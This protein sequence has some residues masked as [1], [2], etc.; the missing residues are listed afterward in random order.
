MKTKV[1]LFSLL[2]GVICIACEDSLSKVGM[3][4]QP[5]EDKI[6]VYDTTMHVTTSTVKLDSIYA[7][8]T[9]G[10]LGEIYDPL[11]GSIKSGYICQYYPA[12]GYD[13]IVGNEIDSVKLNVFYLSMIGDSLTPMEATVFP[14]VKPLDKHYYTNMK[15]SDYCDLNSP[16]VRYPYTAKNNLV[17][18]SLLSAGHYR[19]LTIALP[20][21][22]GQDL[23]E[24]WKKEKPN[25]Y[26]SV[27]EF[28]KF[29][30]G[31]YLTTTFGT[32]SMIPVGLTELY[33]Y[34]TREYT[35]KSSKGEDSLYIAAGA[36]MYTVTKEVIQLNS[37]DSKYEEQLLAPN[38]EKTYVKTPTG[39][40]TKIV[41]PIKEIAD[42]IGQKKFS[43]VKLS[44]KAYENESVDEIFVLPG[45]SS[46]SSP[47]PKMLL[48]EPDS[49][50]K[51]FEEQR[52]A[53][54]K[55]T[56]S[57]TLS[58]YAY[59]FDNISNVVQNAIDKNPEQD[60]ELLL[61]PVQTEFYSSSSSGTVDYS[62]SHYLRPSAVTLK[63][64]KDNLEL[65]IVATD[66]E[67]NEEY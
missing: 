23:F 30:P 57:T 40:Y 65:K 11:Y 3:G 59:N 4:I 9:N 48:I 18:D 35:T 15:V 29:F 5:D 47:R 33:V 38:D 22:M 51:F 44:L 52:V 20:K 19:R 56:F 46:T 54:R 7:K 12:S 67:I 36:A 25:A 21:K 8:S 63:K 32:G 24:E 27:E 61:I 53:D 49:V 2:L 16:I 66:L 62:T 58:N 60:L 1:A 39:I 55:T 6:S 64:G 31:T 14:V 13:S 41:V 42:K 17:S 37:F 43:S 34:Y 28:V 26:S 50:K 45:I 10:Y